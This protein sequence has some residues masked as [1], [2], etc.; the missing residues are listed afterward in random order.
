MALARRTM[1]PAQR[2]MARRQV[3]AALRA[4]TSAQQAVA[5]V[6]QPL[7]SGADVVL[8]QGSMRVAEAPSQEPASHEAVR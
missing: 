8:V 1:A 5:P 3:S 2:A 4:M 6:E 7:V